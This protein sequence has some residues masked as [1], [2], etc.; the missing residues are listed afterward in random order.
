MKYFSRSHNSGE[1]LRPPNIYEYFVDNFWFKTVDLENQ[2]INEPLRGSHKAD[3]VIVGGGFTGLSSAYH[4]WQRFPQK[5]ILLLEGAC[6]GYGASGRNG[7]FCIATSLMDWDETDPE[8]HRQNREV[9]LYGIK[10]IRKLIDEH[11][12]DCDFEENGMLEVALN[13]EQV[14][15]LENFRDN[16][17]GAGFNATLLH[18]KE[19]ETEI[20]SPI[21]IAGVKNHH[22]AI[23]NPAKL[24]REMKRVVE[25]IGVEI[26]ERSLVTRITPGKTHVIDTELGEVRAPILVLATNAYSHKLGFFK[27]YVYP[28]S[29]FQVATEPLSQHQWA[30][31]GWQNRQGLSD[32]RNLYS[33]LI[34]TV[35]G[36][37]VMGGSDFTYY[38]MD[39]LASGNDKKVTRNILKDLFAFFP[40]LKGIQIDH[41][42]G[43][44]TAGTLNYTP[45]VGV[46]GDHRNVYYGTGHSEGVPTTQT[47]GRII[48]D[49]MA[50]ESNEFTSHYIVNRKIPYAGPL[51][52]RGIFA[53]GAKWWLGQQD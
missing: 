2:R 15:A 16:L 25:S 20:K 23:L 5:K 14:R 12:I 36:R 44:T 28:I 43:G 53:R 1:N 35:D 51:K 6:C 13:E 45:S 50:G 3:V 18:G 33:Y 52:L 7:G 48:A 46:I 4:I 10:F 22:G 41:A 31:I 37:I 21:F 42:W 30:S 27:N 38:P 32:M 17:N 26:R 40:C 8:R 29:V 24:V 34:P 49:L 47:A 39:R 11:G 9:S 19:L